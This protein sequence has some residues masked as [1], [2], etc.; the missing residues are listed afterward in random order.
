MGVGKGAE[1]SLGPDL[2]PCK[3]LFLLSFSGLLGYHLMEGKG[4]RLRAPRGRCG[5]LSRRGPQAPV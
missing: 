4:L 1:E 3:G 5:T 2:L